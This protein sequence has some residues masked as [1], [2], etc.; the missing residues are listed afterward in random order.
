MPR[1]RQRRGLSR[2]QILPGLAL[3][4]AFAV[5]GVTAATLRNRPRVVVVPHGD[6]LPAASAATARPAI[7][8]RGEWGA[9]PVNHSA[10]NEFGFY[11]QGRNP[12]GWYVYEGELRDRYQ[13]LIAHHS[14]FYQ[15]DGLATLHEVQRLHREDRLW[16]DI[17][18]HFLVDVDGT[19]YEGRELAARGVHTKDHNTGS[20]GLCLLGDYRFEA[21]PAAQWEAAIA[22]GRWLVE[23]LALTHLA[24]HSQFNPSTLCPGAAMLARLPELALLLGV[25]YG[26]DGYVPTALAASGCGCPARL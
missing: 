14:A 1:G 17:G 18:Y 7:V 22:L 24:G 15:A 19:I 9:L 5:G 12:A 2:R 21:P 4:G 16:A 3:V 20:A 11:Q 13:T 26:A 25:E 10:R 23:T 6:D 8:K